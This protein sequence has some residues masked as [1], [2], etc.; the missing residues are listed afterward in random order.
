MVNSIAMGL[1]G[2]SRIRRLTSDIR[3]GLLATL[4]ATAVGAEDIPGLPDVG[5]FRVGSV[6][7][8]ERAGFSGSPKVQVF[9]NFGDP[10]WPAIAFCLEDPRVQVEMEAFTGVLVNDI[11]EPNVER[12]F[13]EG[14]GLQVI[15]RAL[16]GGFLG[17]LHRGFSCD[18]L[19]DLLAAIRASSSEPEKS[20]IYALLV[21]T[22]AVID[23]V[24][25]VDGCDRAARF[26]AFLTE[27]EGAA[28]PTTVQ[29]DTLFRAKCSAFLR[30]DG[31]FDGRLDVADAVTILGYLFLGEPAGLCEDAA[32]T[33][34]SGRLTVGDATRLL[35]YLF[36]DG[37]AVPPAPF[38]VAGLDPTADAI[39]CLLP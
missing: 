28:S 37:K 38:P 22:P 33:D 26:V 25:D 16:N 5:K 8:E 4:L 29:V 11:L 3:V 6:L 15:V 18:E 13:R 31:N 19:V 30:G 12:E 1:G 20:P 32:D 35:R 21:D 9:T 27:F 23:T 24:I 10:D 39:D 7:G 17:A 36:L 34:D 14:N 2:D